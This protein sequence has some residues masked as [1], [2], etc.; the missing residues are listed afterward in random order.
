MRV[1]Q[2]GASPLVLFVV[3]LHTE[4]RYIGSWDVVGV[5]KVDIII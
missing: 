3:V 1:A 4:E 5:A 2:C